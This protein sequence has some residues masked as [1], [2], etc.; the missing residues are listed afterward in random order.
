MTVTV[1]ESVNYWMVR[2]AID[3]HR[4]C[5]SFIFYAF[6]V[7]LFKAKVDVSVAQ[8]TVQMIVASLFKV[9]INSNSYDLDHRH[10]CLVRQHSWYTYTN[11]SLII[12]VSAYR[13]VGKDQS[14][15]AGSLQRLKSTLDTIKEAAS[16]GATI[17][18]ANEAGVDTAAAAV[19]EKGKGV[20]DMEA[21]KLLEVQEVVEGGSSEECQRCL[22]AE[23]QMSSSFVTSHVFSAY[24][25]SISFMVWNCRNHT[26]HPCA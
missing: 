14:G 23:R 17:N 13:L 24:A 9:W 19:E 25:L 2:H 8:D 3:R 18:S 15:E 5:M 16:K 4:Q 12:L 6:H 20:L 10:S 11:R 26:Y 1:M 7:S 22:N 21:V